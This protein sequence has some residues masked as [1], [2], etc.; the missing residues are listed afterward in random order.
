MSPRLILVTGATGFVGSHLVDALLE[1]GCRVRALVRRTSNLRWLEGKPVELAFADLR[2]PAALREAMAGVEAVL[3][4][5]GRIKARSKREFFEANADGT[6][7]LAAAFLESAPSGGG[8][9]FLYCSS[10]A[11]S[12]PARDPAR[13]PFPHVLEDDL[14][15]PVSDYG[16]SKLEG[17]RRLEMIGDRARTVILRPPA[18]YGPR[19]EAILVLMRWAQRGWFPIPARRGATFALVHVRD[20]VDVTMRAV[21]NPAARGIYTVSDGEVHRWEEIGALVGRVLGKRLRTV[22]IP[23]TVAW[24]AAA[25]AELIAALGGPAALVSFGKVREMRESCWVCLADRA[26]RDLAFHPGT[27]VAAGMEETI[28]WYQARGW[29]RGGS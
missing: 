4:F 19:D 20:L 26:A 11:A 8:G 14:P 5:G 17:E 2:E 6:A 24:L 7:S 10:M 29:I 16:E 1:R 23:I 13:S 25:S 3:H 12:G 18:V 27:G 9:L 21:E 28:R 22:R 15:H